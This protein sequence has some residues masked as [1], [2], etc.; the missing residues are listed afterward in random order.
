[1]QALFFR[2]CAD[3]NI[4]NLLA[5][6]AASGKILKNIYMAEVCPLKNLQNKILK[7]FYGR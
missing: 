1:M 6:F 3:L 4:T 5:I 2:G 7:K